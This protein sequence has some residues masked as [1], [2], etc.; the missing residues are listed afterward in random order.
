MQTDIVAMR[1]VTAYR[2]TDGKLHDS[3]DEAQCRQAYLDLTAIIQEGDT[4]LSTTEE[5]GMIADALIMQS[6]EVLRLLRTI[7]KRRS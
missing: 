3:R 5:A 4:T 7:D 6:A 1:R 2:T